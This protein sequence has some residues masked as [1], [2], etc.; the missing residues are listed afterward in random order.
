MFS[1]MDAIQESRPNTRN[2]GRP[3][4]RPGTSTSQPRTPKTPQQRKNDEKDGDLSDEK[5]WGK[6]NEQR[7]YK[8][9]KDYGYFY[10]SCAC[11]IEQPTF[12][13]RF[14]SPLVP[15]VSVTAGPVIGE[16]TTSSCK[17]LLECNGS[18]KVRCLARKAHNRFNFDENQL[19]DLATYQQKMEELKA[20]IIHQKNYIRYC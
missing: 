10:I 1:A 6:I 11:D 8:W 3:A 20:I 14:V 7:E 17:V 16:V 12:Y 13:K 5:I 15:D 9:R 4:S 18:V 2:G 19:Q